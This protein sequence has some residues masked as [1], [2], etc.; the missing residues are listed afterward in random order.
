MF[1]VQVL[2]V[3]S[4]IILFLVLGNA[5]F[6]AS[7]FSLVSVRQ[8][9]IDE[10]IANGNKR[11]KIVK[12]VSEKQDDVISATQLGIT[13][14]SIALGFVAEQTF[15][16]LLEPLHL[17][18]LLPGLEFGISAAIAFLAVTYLHVVLGELAPKSVALQFAEATSLWVAWPM[19]KFTTLTKPA[20]KL[21]NGTAWFILKIFGIRPIVGVVPHSE[22][23][24]KLLISQSEEAG[25]LD[26]QESTILQKTFDLPDTMIREIMTPRVE[27]VSI[28]VEEPFKKIV[29]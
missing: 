14:A 20:I 8:S 15:E 18:T 10:L 16:I 7:E 23:E 12:R 17:D 6:V 27:L 19:E 11:A 29:K 21:F 28:S 13:L 26:T 5:F 9:R 25:L 4:I 24:L 22:D 3:N 1:D 2:L